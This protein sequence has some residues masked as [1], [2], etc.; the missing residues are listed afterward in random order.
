MAERQISALAET[1]NESFFKAITPEGGTEWDAFVRFGATVQENEDFLAKFN[2][3]MD[4]FGE[5][6]ARAF[7]NLEAIT[8]IMGEVTAA[9]EALGQTSYVNNFQDLIV[10]WDNLIETLNELNATSE[11]IQQTEANRNLVLG[12]SITGIS[13]ESIYQGLGAGQSVGDI[14]QKSLD[15]MINSQLAASIFDDLG[16]ILEQAG[17]QF[18]NTGGDIEAAIS[19]L[20]TYKPVISEMFGD[21]AD[22]IE[23]IAEVAEKFDVQKI[24]DLKI[25]E[26]QQ[27]TGQFMFSQ[28][29][30]VWGDYNVNYNA[31]TESGRENWLRW[32]TESSSREISNWIDT[33][34][35]AGDQF[36]TMMQDI[37]DL[38]MDL[39]TARK[40]AKSSIEDLI[41]DLT[42]SELAPVTSMARYE[43]QYEQLLSGIGSATSADE[44]SEAVSRFTAF[45]P[46]ILRFATAYGGSAGDDWYQ[47][48]MSDLENYGGSFAG[49]GV[50]YGPN[51]GYPVTSHGTEAHIPMQNGTI[52]VIVEGGSPNITV[53][54]R[55]GDRELRDLTFDVIRTDP[56]T[57]RQ[58]RRVANV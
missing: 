17:Q 46:D 58:I 8:G 28:Y 13:A 27:R 41:T 26:I 48:I 40:A 53:V 33:A 15:A 11:K 45:V 50:S 24:I 39:V 55:V 23:A 38:E 44:I 49:G 4:N 35:I 18:I 7:R 1:F 22:G 54:V 29:R 51:T 20:E 21:I 19:T 31:N 36:L 10:T 34:D 57:Q 16:P 2:A 6:T 12:A 32:F 56:E 43:N 52:P 42:F 37:I 30:D 25:Y 9:V 5:S 14:V 47:R 3:R